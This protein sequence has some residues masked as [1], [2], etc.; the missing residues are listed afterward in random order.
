MA[1]RLGF[2]GNGGL[3]DRQEAKAGFAPQ[4]LIHYF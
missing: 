3:C 1:D 4:V 2:Y